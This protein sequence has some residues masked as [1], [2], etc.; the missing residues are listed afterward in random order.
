MRLLSV[1]PLATKFQNTLAEIDETCV[2]IR[3]ET[4]KYSDGDELV[5]ADLTAAI[6]WLNALRSIEVLIRGANAH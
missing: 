5:D 6:A 3:E 1:T 4:A 2:A